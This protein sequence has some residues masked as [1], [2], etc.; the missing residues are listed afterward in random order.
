MQCGFGGAGSAGGDADR[1]RQR[2]GHGDETCLNVS[3]VWRPLRYGR[4]EA[5]HI[6]AT[7]VIEV[8]SGDTRSRGFEGRLHYD[9]LARALPVDHGRRLDAF[10]NASLLNARFTASLIPLQFGNFADRLWQTG[11][12]PAPER[13]WCAGVRLES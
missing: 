6:N 2:C 1:P 12:E 10:I 8:N 9:F 13:S 3:Q 11:L 7:D 5:H 4:I